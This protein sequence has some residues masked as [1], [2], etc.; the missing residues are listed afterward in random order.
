[1]FRLSN[2]ER[3]LFEAQLLPI[4]TEQTQHGFIFWGTWPNIVS[5]E[6]EI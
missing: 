3:E 4:P 2:N 5:E 6:R 1:M